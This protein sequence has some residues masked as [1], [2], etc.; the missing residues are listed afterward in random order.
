[1]YATQIKNNPTLI[2]ALVLTI[3][4]LFMAIP[5]RAQAQ[6]PPASPA[7]GSTLEQRV[8][9]RKAERK[10][11]IVE[12]DQRRQATTCTTAQSKIRALQQ[13]T[14]PA[15]ANRA[16]VN[17]QVDAKLWIM[18]GKLKIA[19]KDTFS[20]EKQRATLADKAGAAQQTAANYSQ[21]LDDIATINCKADFEGFK[22]LL[23]TARIYRTQLRDQLADQRN[24]VNNDVKATL[25]E[26]A[27]ELQAKASTGGVR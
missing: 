27:K 3:V 6:V 5:Q 4:A 12:A 21:A 24:Y 18:I 1:M 16:K 9:Q 13:K 7:A 26:F 2:F 19:D 10:V 25:S 15:I 8:A 17:Q 14:T 11:V 23:D 22:A 20:L